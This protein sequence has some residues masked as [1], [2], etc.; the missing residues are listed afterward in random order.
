MKSL[1]DIDVA[2]LP[3]GGTYTMNAVEAAEATQYIQPKLAIPYH[4]G[5]NVGTLSDA[6]RFAELAD[7]A[8]K[9]LT[10]GETISSKYWPEYSPLVAHW[11]LDE[12]EGNIAYDSA[13]N[14]HGTLKGDPQWVSGYIDG[15]LEFDG[16]GDYV[17]VGSVGI[18]GNVPK[19][20]AGWAKASTTD[21]PSWTTVFGFAHNGSGNTTYHDIEV[22]DTGHYVAHINGYQSPIIAVD[23]QWHHFVFTYDG[24][25][26]SWYL[27]GQLI[28]RVD[29]GGAY[30]STVDEVRIG[31][32]LSYSNYFPGIIDDVRIYNVALSAEEIEA[33]AP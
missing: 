15:A 27:D 12:T 9:I 11:K 1:G 4:W 19:T 17:D 29:A 24:I 31:A 26:T 25:A 20:I 10:V 32:R 7:C 23:T 2:I 30:L 16:D 5:R 8:V 6:E 3:A 28:D 21:I 22:D 13:G 14:N 33:L 18:S